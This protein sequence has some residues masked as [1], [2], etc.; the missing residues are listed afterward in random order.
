MRILFLVCLLVC[1]LGCA[2]HKY[3]LRPDLNF[4]T[5]DNQGLLIC[6]LDAVGG[7]ICERDLRFYGDKVLFV[8]PSDKWVK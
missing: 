4:L 8:V 1:F 7:K 3:E 6:R 5:S 2:I